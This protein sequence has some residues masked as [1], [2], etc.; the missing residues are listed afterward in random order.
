MLPFSVFKDLSDI[1]ILEEDANLDDMSFSIN[2]GYNDIMEKL[3]DA[4]NN[5]FVC[6]IYYK[7][8]KK[9]IVLD[10]FRTIEPYAVGVSRAG[11]T[12]VR[13]WMSKGIS[14]TG[15]LNRKLVPGWRLYRIDRITTLN[16]T[17]QKFLVPH[18]GYNPKDM[19]MTEVMFSA[20]F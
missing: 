2:E 14:K 4:I 13:A 10:G 11:N 17:L 8:E 3:E 6:T 5:K 9:G 16:V 20:Q 1:D 15:K 18:K 19:N 7:G 12:V